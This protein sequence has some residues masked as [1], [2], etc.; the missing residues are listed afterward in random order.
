MEIL[1]RTKRLEQAPSSD[2]HLQQHDG[3]E[4]YAAKEHETSRPPRFA[5]V[6]YQIFNYLSVHRE[7][8]VVSFLKVNVLIRSSGHS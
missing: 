1:Y 3:L 8:F 6:C 4:E 5:L 2:L 7:R